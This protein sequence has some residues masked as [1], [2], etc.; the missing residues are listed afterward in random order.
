MVVIVVVNMMLGGGGLRLRMRIRMRSGGIGGDR[1]GGNSAPDAKASVGRERTSTG[2]AGVGG[3]VVLAGGGQVFGGRAARHALDG[4]DGSGN[5]FGIRLRP[6]EVAGEEWRGFSPAFVCGWGGDGLG[7][8]RIK[9]RIGQ[10]IRRVRMVSAHGNLM[11]D[12][13]GEFGR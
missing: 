13:V 8:L 5:G 12:I 3:P 9:L 11:A 1:R 7:V 10:W 6:T 4:F 2:G